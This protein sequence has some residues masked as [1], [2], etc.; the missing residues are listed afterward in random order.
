MTPQQFA[1][2]QEQNDQAIGAWKRFARGAPKGDFRE[3]AGIVWAFSNVPLSFFNMAFLSRPVEDANDLEQR[4]L[5]SKDYGATS[6]SAWMFFSFDEWLP[7]PVQRSAEDAFSRHGLRPAMLLT[8]MVMDLGSIPAA[9]ASPQSSL[10]YR[11]VVD[12]ETCFAI[13]DVNCAAYG[14]PVE[15]GRDSILEG[16]FGDDVFAYVGYLEDK[17][18]TAA[19]VWIVDGIL[20]VAMVA[21]HP[22]QRR[23]GYAD[24]VMW[25][26]LQEARRATGITRTV[27][28]ATEAGLPVYERMGYRSVARFTL[29]TEAHQ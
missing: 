24:A 2:L 14:M 13:S 9:T 18:V 10:E 22:D 16:M 28:H 25:H 8:G 1:E 7:E 4:I 29:Y 12:R 21:T 19:G 23:K 6:G 15:I 11:R 3:T 27:L 20:Y 17:P 26:S 5:V